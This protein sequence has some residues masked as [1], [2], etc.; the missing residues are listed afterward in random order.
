MQ[1]PKG[2]LSATSY[3]HLGTKASNFRKPSNILCL[4][5][6]TRFQKRLNPFATLTTLTAKSIPHQ[7]Q[8]TFRQKR[9]C[10]SLSQ[11]LSHTNFKRFGPK[12]AVAVIKGLSAMPYH[13]LSTKASIFRGKPSTWHFL[14]AVTG[15]QK[16]F[17]PLTTRTAKSI[18]P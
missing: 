12:T 14:V 13:H 3:D 6:V 17:N 1:C 15:F 18:P 4:V 8:V 10:R 16:S 11:N 7:F 5:A 9:V 2:V